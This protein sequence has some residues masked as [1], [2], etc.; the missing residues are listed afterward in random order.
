MRLEICQK[1]IAEQYLKLQ[2][3]N[4]DVRRNEGRKFI[5]STG[6]DVCSRR[7]DRPETETA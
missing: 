5:W 6:K 7:L 4:I 3:M 2:L 1:L